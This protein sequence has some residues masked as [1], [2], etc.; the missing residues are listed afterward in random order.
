MSDLA[1]EPE[2]AFRVTEDGGAATVEPSALVLCG[3]TARDE[4]GVLEHIEELA[5]EG[6]PAPATIP[7][8][9]HVPATL[10]TSAPRIEVA[11]PAT[12]GEVEPVLVHAGGEWHLTVGSDHT[13]RALER[14]DMLASKAACAKP[15]CAETWPL[16]SVAERWEQLI[17]R[18]DVRR[19]GAWTAY[20][21]AA[22]VHLRPL[23]E[24]LRLA[25]EQLDPLPGAVLFLGTP[26]LKTGGF[27]YGDAYKLELEDPTSG[28]ELTC[29]YEVS[30]A[31]GS[32]PDGGVASR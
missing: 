29:T 12:S 26:P 4:A 28:R 18:C 13:D 7:A 24:L 9:W 30:A 1:I 14:D 8:F 25:G 31:V 5:R 22:L 21:E 11:S 6:I 19:D 15:V 16:A 10:V 27:V 3:Y 20:Q 17:V 23:E 32:G 2:R